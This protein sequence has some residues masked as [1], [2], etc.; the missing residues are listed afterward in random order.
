[1]GPRNLTLL[2][3]P[4]TDSTVY[5]T[6][7]SDSGSGMVCQGQKGIL[8][9]SADVS[10]GPSSSSAQLRQDLKIDVETFKNIEPGEPEDTAGSLTPLE[11][12][13]SVYGCVPVH[14]SR[15]PTMQ[16]M[17]KQAVTMV[18]RT[19]IMKSARQ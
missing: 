4:S 8:K 17:P 10:A 6:I 5:S 13:D 7:L 19:G 1:M 14:P 3:T 2:H 15:Q 16:H 12:A 11:P 18:R 9:A